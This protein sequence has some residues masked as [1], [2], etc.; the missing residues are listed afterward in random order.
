M[1]AGIR[2]R[3]RRK[4]TMSYLGSKAAS[5]VYQKI[6][7]QMPPHDTYIETHLGG[8]AVM[9]RKPPALRNVGI[10]LDAEALQSFAF[11][12]QLSHVNLVNRDAVEYLKA[13]DF[14]QRRSRFGLRRS[15][16]STGNAHQ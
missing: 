8:G 5:G 10:D 4:K 16:L 7:A 9:Q 14:C 12:H 3:E 6:I 2:Q 11:S 15:T 1:H 13:F